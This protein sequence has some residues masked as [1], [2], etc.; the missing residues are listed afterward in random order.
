MEVL[1]IKK[2]LLRQPETNTMGKYPNPFQSTNN[3]IYV[4]SSQIKQIEYPLRI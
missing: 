2:K 1:N 3:N 4:Q